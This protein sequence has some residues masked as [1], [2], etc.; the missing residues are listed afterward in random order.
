VNALIDDSMELRWLA[1]ERLIPLEGK[2]PAP[3]LQALEVDFESPF[4]QQGGHHVLRALERKRKLNEK[5]LAV[6]DTPRFPEPKMEVALAAQK[7]LD[8]SER[9]DGSNPPD[10]CNLESNA[11]NRLPLMIFHTAE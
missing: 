3:L 8:F 9:P 2:A 6:V 11:R 5:I 4:L 7:A 10:L 1:P